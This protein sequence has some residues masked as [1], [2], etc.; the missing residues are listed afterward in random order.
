M[1][2]GVLK[3]S[4]LQRIQSYGRE[5]QTETVYMAAKT[6]DRNQEKD[7]GFL[8]DSFTNKKLGNEESSFEDSFSIEEKA[9]ER[10]RFSI[11]RILTENPSGRT[12][13]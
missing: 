1:G 2:H 11:T 13:R 7:Q 12:L 5:I 9:F 3:E 8:N 4:Q 10:A 6:L